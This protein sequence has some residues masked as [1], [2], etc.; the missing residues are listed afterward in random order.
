[1]RRYPGTAVGSGPPAHGTSADAGRGRAARVVST[2]VNAVSIDSPTVERIGT[3]PTALLYEA[4]GKL[5][6]MSGEVRPI[7][8]GGRLAGPAFTVRCFPADMRAVVRAIDLARP[9]DV[10]VIDVGPQE[11]TTTWGGT[12]SLAAR[13]RGLAG[14]VTNGAVRDVEEVVEVGLPVFATA[15]R[16]QGVLKNHPGWIGI[17]V[18]VGGVPVHS[19]DLV[20]ADADGVVVVP[21]DRLDEVLE[22]APEIE[23]AEA[24]KLKHVRAGG[25]LS[26]FFGLDGD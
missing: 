2:E 17:P 26:R 14:C 22:R 9:G 21:R 7:V 3:W 5:G 19:G 24:D 13:N 1:M 16:P 6:G 4:A 25:S 23:R 12:A 10:L 20:V 18:A 8:P 15:V 11:R